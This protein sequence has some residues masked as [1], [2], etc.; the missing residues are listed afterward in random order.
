[1]AKE[2]QF[3]YDPEADDEKNSKALRLPFALCKKYGITIQDWWTPRNAWDALKNGGFVGDVSEEYKEFYKEQKKE[4]QKKR[5][6]ELKTRN[7]V[8]KA[9]LKNPE[10]NPDANY[11]HK[12][13]AISGATKGKPMTFEEADSGNCNPYYS[14]NFN[15]FLQTGSVI[16]YATNCQTCVATYVARRQGYDVRALPNLNNKEIAQLSFNTNLIYSEHGETTHIKHREKKVAFFERICQNEGD[17]CSVE[18]SWGGS[19]RGHIVIAEK[20]NGK[21]ILYDPQTNKKYDNEKDI[22]RLLMTAKDIKATN[23]TNAK[24]NETYADKCMKGVKK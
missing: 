2:K 23:L 11:T 5:R 9:Q 1:M 17:I 15:P 10:H 24:I 16:G 6:E 19:M 18:W 14:K 8:K 13:G 22:Q 7:A 12:D 21:T 4:S 3:V 20:Q